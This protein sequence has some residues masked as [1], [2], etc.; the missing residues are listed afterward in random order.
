MGRP[1]ETLRDSRWLT[2]I[3]WGLDERSRAMLARR[4]RNHT[5]ESI[6]R[7][8]GVTRERARQI[9]E[10]AQKKLLV[11]ASEADA[12]WVILIL[13]LLEGQRAVSDTELSS[14]MPDD[15][16]VIRASLLMAEGLFH[17]KP[18]SGE[19]A[20][21]WA[22]SPEAL[23]QSLQELV[24]KAPHRPE[25]L[26]DMARHVGIPATIDIG[27]IMSSSRSPLELDASGVWVRRSAKKRDAAYLWLA[28]RGEPAAPSAI[29]NAIESS[30]RAVTAALGRDDR[31]RQLRPDRTWALAEW[32]LRGIGHHNNALDVVIEVLTDLGPLSQREL[33]QEVRRRYSV[34]DS[35]I[36]QCLLSERI[37]QTLDGRVGLI[38]RGALVVEEREPRRPDS[39]VHDGDLR[40]LAFRI[41]VDNDI[42]R[43]S[44]VIISP[45]IT[46]RLG[47]RQAPTERTFTL[48][49]N[50]RPISFR[51]RTSAA[52]MSSLRL[53]ISERGLTRGCEL[54]AVLR[55]EVDTMTIRHVCDP[56][57][58][59]AR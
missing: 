53:E 19:I 32:P 9:I 16:G 42:V 40:L 27:S 41:K 44:G 57:V 1:Y 22:P 6:G 30:V 8:H 23:D 43:G 18:W 51:R 11:A 36:R 54:A 50:G 37:G 34:S 33:S 47:L 20:D 21:H 49:D 46:W 29:A 56:S 25:D 38:E 28:A 55:L 10:D 31:F 5:L 2:E 26:Q 12:Q 7:T 13:E 52:L 4:A 58:C 15:S 59:P 24:R 14:V 3:W 39:A 45:W 17:P 48:E 35:R